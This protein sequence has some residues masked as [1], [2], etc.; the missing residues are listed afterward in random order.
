MM[1]LLFL[2]LICAI[3]C[4]CGED[5]QLP[6]ENQ[7]TAKPQAAVKLTVLVVD[8]AELAKG[9]NLLR[10]EWSE[11]SGGELVVVE[12]TLADLLAEKTPPGDVVIYPSR[13]VGELVMRNWLRP[14]REVV[15]ADPTLGW[16]DFLTMIRDQTVRF[17]GEVFAVSLGEMPLALAWEGEVPENLPTTWSQLGEQSARAKKSREQP[18]P[19]ASEFIARALAA[20]P[21][22]DRAGLF[23]DA[24]SFDA[25]LTTPQLV[26]ALEEMAQAANAKPFTA[27]VALP[28]QAG[29]ARLSPLLTAEEV[30]ST[31][32]EEW[33][34]RKE[35]TPPVVCGF[36]GR[37]VSVTTSS[38]NAASAFK[39]LPWLVSGSTG[40]QLSQRS[41]ATLWFRASQVSQ[42][43][44]W[45]AEGAD[46]NRV[47]WLTAAMSRGDAYLLPRI[48]SIDQ[49]LME[50][51]VG[52][53]AAVA[54]DQTADKAL[55]EVVERWNALSDELGRDSQR[56]AFNR[57]LGL[58]E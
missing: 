53:V 27:A 50:L 12:S 43:R 58:A 55:A 29:A 32:L 6:V 19:L 56:S 2:V 42:G 44:K 47:S 9:I 28:K 41:A 46:D 14:V 36:G 51:E 57:H 10:G 17:G 30:Y 38:R 13:H 21:P 54:G 26:R 22:A 4:G 52:L 35:S 45:F 20:T 7:K 16:G 48:S 23:F 24:Q 3:S 5:A 49:Y 33:E 15:L 11:R 18:F 1:R 37:L 31:S 39:L 8:D 25:K 34:A 40:T